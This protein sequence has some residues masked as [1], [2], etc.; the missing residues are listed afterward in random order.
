MMLLDRQ[1][2]RELAHSELSRDDLNALNR[3]DELNQWSEEL[4]MQVFESSE[5]NEQQ[6]RS[7][8]EQMLRCK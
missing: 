6:A 4:I 3:L 2:W 8:L 7:T 5:R 1:R